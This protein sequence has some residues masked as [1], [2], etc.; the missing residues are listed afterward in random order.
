MDGQILTYRSVYPIYAVGLAKLQT[1]NQ[2]MAFS[3][4]LR[5]RTDPDGP[6]GSIAGATFAV[7]RCFA[8]VPDELTTPT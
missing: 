2:W 3:R 1:P 5:E 6:A 7:L 4:Q 8:A